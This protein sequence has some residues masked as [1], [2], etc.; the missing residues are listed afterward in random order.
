MR[1]PAS[2]EDSLFCMVNG[3]YISRRPA[4]K[5]KPIIVVI[6]SHVCTRNNSHF[7]YLC[8]IDTLRT[9]SNNLHYLTLPKK[10]ASNP[11]RL[12]AMMVPIRAVTTI[13]T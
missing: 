3:R 13:R 7:E 5:E 6:I 12:M 8:K 11:V 4:A 10:R 9:S 2:T 1:Y